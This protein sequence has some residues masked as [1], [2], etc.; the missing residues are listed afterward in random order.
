V[1]RAARLIRDEL[2]KL[3][4]GDAAFFTQNAANYV[5]RL[6]ALARW[7]RLEVAKIPRNRRTL[8]TTHDA[9]Q[10]LAKEFGFT[11]R[12]VTGIAAEEQPSSRHVAALIAAIKSEKVKAI[13]AENIENPKVLN[14][15]TRETGVKLGGILYP[16]GLADGEAGTYEGMFRHN[17]FTIVEALK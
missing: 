15:I 1:Q 13:F 10:Y 2:A 16:D 4:P 9:F 11:I 6:E 7:A 8:V 14:E 17:I 3:R 5:D 12:S